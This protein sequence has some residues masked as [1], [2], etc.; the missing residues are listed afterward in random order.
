M[1]RTELIQ[2]KVSPE[3]KRT[4][5]K[6]AER[7]GVYPSQFLR[8]V[9]LRSQLGDNELQA[10]MEEDRLVRMEHAVGEARAGKPVEGFP[11][12]SPGTIDQAMLNVTLDEKSSVVKQETE[13][14]GEGTFDEEDW[15][16][17]RAT[18]L[19]ARMPARAA[20]RQAEIEWEE[21]G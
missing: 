10:I 3:E 11:A 16:S 2:V 4:I 1:S 17:R 7:H 12:E 19:K 14:L 6:L 9:G 18:Q 5:R 21:M 13:D 8:A 20:R 15:I